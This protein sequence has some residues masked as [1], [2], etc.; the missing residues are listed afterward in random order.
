MEQTAEGS[1]QLARSHLE[2]VQVSWDDPTDWADLSSYGLYCLEACI[3]AA[4]LHLGQP[5]PSSHRAKVEMAE[6]LS[7]GHDLPY[8]DGLLVDLNQMRKHEAYG[9]I[10]P[11]ENLSPEETAAAIEEYVDSVGTLLAE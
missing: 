8:I 7:E 6:L 5:R 2:R 10:Y 9:D 4:A 1:L 11:P 3:V